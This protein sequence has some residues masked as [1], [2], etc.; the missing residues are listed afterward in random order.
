[1]SIILDALKK[2]EA[3]RHLGALPGLHTSTAS[4]APSVAKAASSARRFVFGIG[5]ASALL[6][7]G[8]AAWWYAGGGAG[9]D[10]RQSARAPQV[11]APPVAV[12]APPAT[13]PITELSAPSREIPVPP[14]VP[15][16]KPQP[17]A[18]PAVAPIPPASLQPK[19]LPPPAPAANQKPTQIAPAPAPA[20][21]SS[22]KVI[23]L[24]ELSPALQ[25]ELPPLVIGGSM[26]SDNA[27]E[28]MLLIDKRLLHEGEE[29]APGL[30]LEKLMPKEAVL[31][32]RGTRFRINF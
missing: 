32:F 3:E 26:Y 9:A 22:E 29:V 14:P 10:G 21:T 5:I 2:A 1:M 7:I 12:N 19:T 30:V 4:S 24:S 17:I 11:V 20:A 13:K 18:A 15:V 8:I 23:A 16:L 6:G 27:A 31:R 25:R 28:R